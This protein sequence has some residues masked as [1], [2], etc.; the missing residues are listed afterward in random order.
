MTRKR[1]IH[2]INNGTNKHY[3][4]VKKDNQIFTGNI[5]SY[6]DGGNELT[7]ITLVDEHDLFP[8][9]E[10][11]IS[12]CS[13]PNFNGSW[14]IHE[15]NGKA[16]TVKIPYSFISEPATKGNYSYNH[17]ERDKYILEMLLPE[18]VGCYIH[19]NFKN[20]KAFHSK[21]AS[22]DVKIIFDETEQT[23]VLDDVTENLELDNLN[24]SNAE[25]GELTINGI[26]N[27]GGRV[28]LPKIIGQT[29]DDVKTYIYEYSLDAD[30]SYQ[31]EAKVLGRDPATGNTS[32]HIKVAGVKRVGDGDAEIIVSV[33]SHHTAEDE[34]AWAVTFNVIDDKVRLAVTGDGCRVIDWVATLSYIKT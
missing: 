16:K 11:V 6:A 5:L 14:S 31:F 29:T 4:L 26:T 30:T 1:N 34:P 3:D 2:V 21:A 18:T 17:Y 12:N 20:S 7:L 15:A 25:I 33:S 19:E 32:S 8:N 9:M 24:V 28:F 10:L 22:I 27:F 13:D 23:P